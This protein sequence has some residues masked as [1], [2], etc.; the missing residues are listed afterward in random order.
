MTSEIQQTKLHQILHTIVR[1]GGMN[2]RDAQRLAQQTCNDTD[3]KMA[4]VFRLFALK[5]NGAWN[6][7]REPDTT[8]L[9]DIPDVNLLINFICKLEAFINDNSKFL[10]R[11]WGI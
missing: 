10:L 5:Y 1:I 11:P 3:E 6:L 9:S 2:K 4:F 7:F 8:Q